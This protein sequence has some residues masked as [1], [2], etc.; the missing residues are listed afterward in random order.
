MA[1]FDHTLAF[2]QHRSI[3]THG[4]IIPL[5]VYLLLPKDQEWIRLVLI[6][7]FVGM[8]AHLSYD[9]F[10]RGWGTYARISIPIYGYLN[11]ALSVIWIGLNVVV[12]LYI[13]LLLVRQG[14]EVGLAIVGLI[15]VFMGYAPTENAFWSPLIA[16]VVALGVALVLPGSA[17]DAAKVMQKRLKT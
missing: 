9:L 12:S 7:V 15:V 11:I 16:L 8:G 2:L 3:V 1:D 14:Y 4:V 6:G 17:A 5:L 13:A 10:P